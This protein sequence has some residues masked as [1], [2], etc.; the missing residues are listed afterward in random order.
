MLATVKLHP[1]KTFTI[2]ARNYLT[3]GYW[4]EVS[5]TYAC[6]WGIFISEENLFVNAIKLSVVQTAVFHMNIVW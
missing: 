6:H 2:L 1:F 5:A 4:N 3:F